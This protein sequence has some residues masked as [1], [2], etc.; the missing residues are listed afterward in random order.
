M[1]IG[2]EGRGEGMSAPAIAIYSARRKK[3][4]AKRMMKYDFT[5]PLVLFQKAL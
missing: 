1:S 5:P 3:N 2:K 4:L